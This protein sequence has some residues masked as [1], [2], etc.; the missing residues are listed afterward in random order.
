[1]T[2]E[3]HDGPTVRALV[4]LDPESDSAAAIEELARL[5]TVIESTR[6]RA[7]VELPVDR[8]AEGAALHGVLTIEPEPENRLHNNVARGL[9]QL[10]TVAATLGLDGSGEIVGVADSGL[11]N[12]SNDATLLADIRGR[13]V[14]IRATVN[15]AAFGVPELRSWRP[16]DPAPQ[17]ESVTSSG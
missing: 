4:Q 14:N 7:L 15:K 8:L 16:A 13:V 2:A 11:D 10:D 3:V 6:R 1:M 9:I 5:G 12:G 17:P